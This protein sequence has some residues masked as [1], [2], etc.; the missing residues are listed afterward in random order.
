MNLLWHWPLAYL[1]R[2]LQPFLAATGE[3]LGSWGGACLAG[4]AWNGMVVSQGVRTLSVGRFAWYCGFVIKW[5]QPTGELPPGSWYFPFKSSPRD[6]GVEAIRWID[7]SCVGGL[8][9]QWC[10]NEAL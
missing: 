1:D 4:C 7:V 8:S 6:G 5:A 9:Q 10:N 2:R 3:E